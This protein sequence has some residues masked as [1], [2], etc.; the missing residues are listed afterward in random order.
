MANEHLKEINV[1]NPETGQ[2]MTCTV[3]QFNSIYK[4]KGFV[5][6]DRDNAEKA[7]NGGRQKPA[8]ARPSKGAGSAGTS[9]KDIAKDLGIDDSESN[10][11]ADP[12]AGPMT[13]AEGAADTAERNKD[14]AK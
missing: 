6:V 11:P 1:Y 14:T 7:A 8:F 10:R 2:N 3:K 4:D 9:A 12:N 5:E 13:F